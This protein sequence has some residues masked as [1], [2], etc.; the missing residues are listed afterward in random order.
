[1][2]TTEGLGTSATV[3]VNQRWACKACM[4]PGKII[5]AAFSRAT[6][7]IGYVV[8]RVLETLWDD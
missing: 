2:S 5:A 1:M 7:D 4:A 3:L 6:S 8:A